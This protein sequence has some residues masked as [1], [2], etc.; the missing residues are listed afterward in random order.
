MLDAPR[1]EQGILLRS[2]QQ[3]T[4][5]GETSTNPSLKRKKRMDKIQ[6]ITP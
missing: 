3:G 1:S 5:H 6:V 2:N 4:S